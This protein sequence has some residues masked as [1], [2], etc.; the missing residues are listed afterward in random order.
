MSQAKN[1]YLYME[2]SRLY[3]AHRHALFVVETVKKLT[4]NPSHALLLAAMYQDAVCV[5]KAGS[6]ANERCSAAVLE[7]VY[8]SYRYLYMHSEEEDEKTIDEAK[9]LISQTHIDIHLSSYRQEGDLA[10]LLDA[11]LA[12]LADDYQSFRTKQNRIMLEN[13]GSLEHNSQENKNF[14]EQFLYLRD[15]IYHTEKA[16]DIFEQNARKN[17]RRYIKG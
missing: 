15:F 6:D 5:P 3:N 4:N 1:H 7:N 2:E 14:L 10:I 17:I 16:R 8:M 12:S 13:Y 11:D 9:E